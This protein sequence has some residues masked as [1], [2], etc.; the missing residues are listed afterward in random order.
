[1]LDH[2]LST[3]RSVTMSLA[4]MA[5]VSMV[6][7]LFILIFAILGVQVGAGSFVTACPFG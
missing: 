2:P 6:V 7:V 5:N 4:A 3:P 1:M